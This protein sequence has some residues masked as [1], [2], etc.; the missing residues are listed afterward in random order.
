MQYVGKLIRKED[1]AAIQ[2]YSMPS[3]KR[4]SSATMPFIVWKNGVIGWS[5]R[6]TMPSTCSLPIT[7]M[8]TARP[9]VS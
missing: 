5:T 4:K 7:P 6:V 1:L 2:G 8:P 3:S 9:C